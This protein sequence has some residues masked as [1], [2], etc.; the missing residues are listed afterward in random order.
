MC[1]K[2]I[3]SNKLITDGVSSLREYHAQQRIQIMDLLD[4][5]KYYLQA[6]VVSIE[7]KLGDLSAGSGSAVLTEVCFLMRPHSLA[8][9]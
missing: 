3:L 1:S 8:L 4:D 7:E 2:Q 9:V 5:G 6:V